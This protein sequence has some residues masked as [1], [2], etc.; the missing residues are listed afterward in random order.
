VTL[1]RLNLA[2]SVDYLIWGIAMRKLKLPVTDIVTEYTK[3][4][5]TSYSLAD[6]Y[7]VNPA[8][9]S[10]LL[11]ARI[12]PDQYERLKSQKWS[13]GGHRARKLKYRL[14]HGL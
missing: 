9:I 14:E 7:G 1:P 10:N 4:Q 3:T 12:E 8:T 2:D 13:L 6:K 5:A 11:K